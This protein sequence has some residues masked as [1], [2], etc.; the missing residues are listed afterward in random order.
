MQIDQLGCSMVSSLL[1]LISYVA[2]SLYRGQKPD[3]NQALIITTSCSAFV[4][5]ISLAAL[6]YTAKIEELGVLH[7]Q[8]VVIL[9]G[10]IALG[11]VSVSSAYA[12]MLSP[13]RLLKGLE[14]AKQ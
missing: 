10:C 2:T 6:T 4:A 3:L 12:S 11:W 5:S 9:I 14:S 1:L 7:D 8:K 13:W